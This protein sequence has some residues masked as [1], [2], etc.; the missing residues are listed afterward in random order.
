[1]DFLAILVVVFVLMWALRRQIL[2]RPG[3]FYACAIACNVL[4]IAN[5]VLPLPRWVLS[6]VSPLMQ[7]GGLGIALFLLVMWIGVFPRES[8]LSRDFRPIRGELSVMACIFIVGHMY[9][10]L[11]SYVPRIIAGVVPKNSVAGAL[12]VA[13]LLLA[14]M[15][16]LGVTSLRSVKRRIKACTWRRIQSL[17]YAFYCLAFVHVLLMLGPSAMAGSER[18]MMMVSIYIALFGGYIIARIARAVLDRRE[19]IDLAKK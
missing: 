3:A 16:P 15:V 2:A 7:K 10:Y 14:L 13:C 4:L 9:A 6:L 5:T 11:A 12:L 1:M 17:A 8:R 18:S 19:Q